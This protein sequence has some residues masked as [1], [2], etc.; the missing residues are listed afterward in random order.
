MKILKI[1][2]LY[3]TFSFIVVFCI[4][5]SAEAEIRTEIS[6]DKNTLIFGVVDAMIFK[7]D[8]A[9]KDSTLFEDI[10]LHETDAGKTFTI[11]SFNDDPHF[12]KFTTYLTNGNNDLLSFIHHFI[13]G[14]SF[15]SIEYESSYLNEV[16]GGN[17]IDL[18]GYRIT[19][20]SL[21]INQLDMTLYVIWVGVIPTFYTN[22]S[23][24]GVLTIGS[25]KPGI[26]PIIEYL[27]LY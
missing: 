18:K 7:L 2:F 1:S 21:Y 20:I 23:F 12:D 24:K 19:D 5:N 22:I 16:V 6:V 9:T 26:T 15:E 4:M 25:I 13:G 27:L 10:V 3:I 14:D 17:G 8:Y 11:S